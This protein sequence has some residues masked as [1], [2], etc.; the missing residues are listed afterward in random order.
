[1]SYLNNRRKTKTERLS[2]IKEMSDV[3]TN[4]E[5][6]VETQFENF[7]K[8]II[9]I[10]NNFKT[11]FLML[12]KVLHE[13]VSLDDKDKYDKLLKD[14]AITTRTA[15]RLI[16]VFTDNRIASVNVKMLPNSWTTAH[17]LTQLSDDDFAKVKDSISPNAT[18]MSYLKILEQV[19]EKTVPSHF[20]IMSVK[21]PIV[22][23]DTANLI[24]KRFRQL[25]DD[26]KKTL[27]VDIEVD[28]NETYYKKVTSKSEK[29]TRLLKS[30]QDIKL[31]KREVKQLLKNA[32]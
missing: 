27:E 7:K 15:E 6:A 23:G 10:Q 9:K 1:M 20:D 22:S 31:S 4:K 19:P 25:T 8:Q 30:L 26:L 2:E 18:K 32:A 16:K 5:I 21:L 28:D 3:A 13:A 12:G 24:K 14:C 17:Y 29:K 11:H